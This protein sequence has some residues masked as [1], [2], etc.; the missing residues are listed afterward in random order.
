MPT[1]ALI[2]GD[3]IGHGLLL[4]MCHDLRVL[5]KSFSASLRIYDGP[6]EPYLPTKRAARLIDACVSVSSKFDAY[7][8]KLNKL[9]K[10]LN[11]RE[12][13]KI[14]VVQ[15]IGHLKEALGI[16][17]R[18]GLLDVGS[19]PAYLSRK[20]EKNRLAISVCDDEVKSNRSPE[21]K[22]LGSLEHKL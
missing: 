11:S 10:G 15:G 3:A 13:L 22:V 1:L 6:P 19:D 20:E 8:L 18:L 14:G 2:N 4:A 9:K 7:Q 21:R 17:R 16:I 12:A 5:N